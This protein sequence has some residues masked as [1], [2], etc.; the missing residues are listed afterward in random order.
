[1]TYSSDRIA[2]YAQFAMILEVCATPKPGNVDREHNYPETHFEHF[3]ASSV[4]VYPVLKKASTSSSGIGKYIHDSVVESAKWQGGG[5]THFGAFILLIPLV[6]AGGGLSGRINGTPGIFPELKMRTLELV[7]DTTVD[8]AVEL[9]RA[10]ADAGVRVND[11]DGLDLADPAS[12]DA[13]RTGGTTLYR[14]MKISSSYDMI[15]REWTAGY[16]LTFACANSILEKHANLNIN[17]SVV[18][19]FLEIMAENTDTFIQTKFDEER[20]RAVSERAK[21]II[22][23]IDSAGFD[24]AKREIEIFDE[25]LLSAGINPGSTADIIIAGLFAALVGGLRF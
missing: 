4:S 25:E 7:R 20:A 14:L 21:Q 1:M 12:I 3:L 15:A 13:I 22:Q 10:F 19:T 11:V 2:Q 16:P 18:W 9:Y 6:M 8:D 24:S 5:N 23:L 17:D